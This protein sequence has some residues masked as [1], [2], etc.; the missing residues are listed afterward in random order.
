MTEHETNGRKAYRRA[1]DEGEFV[2]E[3]TRRGSPLYKIDRGHSSRERQMVMS[4]VV[5]V[6][7]VGF[8][9]TIS[10]HSLLMEMID[11][12]A[13][14]YAPAGGVETRLWSSHD[15]HTR[16]RDKSG[17]FANE[18]QSNFVRVE[19]D[20][21]R[22]E[23]VMVDAVGPGAVTRFWV[24][25]ANT[26]GRGVLRIYIDGALAVEGP[27][28]EVLS[29]GRLCGAPLSDSVSPLSPYLQR[30]H[31]LYLPI[32]YARSCKVTYESAKVWALS[33]AEN[34][35]YNVETRTF[36]ACT[37]VRPFSL[38]ELAA[39]SNTVTAVN[40]ALRAAAF[41]APAGA[42]IAEL[43]A[44]LQPGESITRSFTGPGAIRRLALKLAGALRDAELRLAFDG[45][46]AVVVP[47][48]DF[49]GCA[50]NRSP[51]RTW[52][53]GV[54]DD[55]TLESLWVMPFKERCQLTIRNTGTA[56]LTLSDAAATVSDYRWDDARSMHF[57]ATR[58]NYVNI[59]TRRGVDVYTDLAC[60]K[61]NGRGVFIGTSLAV[62]NRSPKWWGE[63]DEKVF[64]D[65]EYA[66]SYI[67][68][69]SEDYFGYAWG[70]AERI[71][72]HPFIAQPDG[73]G[74][75]AVGVVQNNRFRV[76]D[77]IAFSR[78]LDFILEL[79]HWDATTVDFAPTSYWYLRPGEETAPLLR[80]VPRA[81]SFDFA[82]NGMQGWHNRVWVTNANGGAWCDLPA[83][84]TELPYEWNGGVIY[85]ADA[86]NSLFRSTTA[87][88]PF[89]KGF[90]SYLTLGQLDA[91]AN[92]KWVRS[93]RF[94][95]GDGGIK[96]HLIWGKLEAAAEP[97]RE[98]DVPAVARTANGWTGVVLCD[99]T[100]GEFVRRRRAWG[101]YN[102]VYV[103]CEF[104]AA[105]LKNLDRSHVYTLDLLTLRAGNESWVALDEVTISGELVEPQEVRLAPDPWVKPSSSTSMRIR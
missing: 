45:H 3:K 68:T 76:L 44:V 82:E 92:T 4:M 43:N 88:Y 26:D 37:E 47:V 87:N 78:S 80:K 49:F 39:E 79:N 99:A 84:A 20:A 22:R 55:G 98:S 58:A 104:T 6:A 16:T 64:V 28:A 42:C 10:L 90:G 102:G 8:S 71:V 48:G 74:A 38:R 41:T 14:T 67:G 100:T 77:T 73:T 23:L 86:G 50:Y 85:P 53:G 54:A 46:E 105:E 13:V 51:F 63:G 21:S 60:V 34:F 19:G 30:G 32:P 66:P 96:F 35:Y 33:G 25:L 2:S 7:M 61:L 95:L 75:T 17:W 9:E 29:G 62:N 69:G 1:N 103:P 97:L 24:T 72:A 57:G 11:R 27:V 70:R 101:V 36:P 89:D 31:N 18:D 56:A 12:D 83:G 5:A 15:R 91:G 93:P 40:A 94:R 65:D 52:Y 59:P 81:I